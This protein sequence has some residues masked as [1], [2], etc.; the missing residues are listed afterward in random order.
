MT[1]YRDL[2]PLPYFGEDSSETLVAIGW[3]GRD[4]PFSKGS[5]PPAVFLRLKRLLLQPFQPI[6]SAGVHECELCQFEAERRGST[7]LFV[8]ADRRLFVCPELI[9]HYMNAHQYQPPRE[10]C[11]AVLMCPDTHT[12]EYKRLLL[13]SGGRRLVQDAG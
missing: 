12:M 4:Q 7:N 1:T 9:T 2:G 3:L 13:A 11:D 5:T 6:V 10:F 8:P